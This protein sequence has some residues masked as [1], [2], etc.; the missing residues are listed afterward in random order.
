[1]NWKFEKV[2]AG[3]EK[4]GIRD[5]DI[6]VFDKFRIPSVVR[7]SIQ[8]SLDAV[9]ND[10]EPVR[11]EFLFGEIDKS[12]TTELFVIEDHIKACFNDTKKGTEDFEVLKEM[13][14]KISF[15]KQSIPYLKISDFNTLGMERESAYNAFAF[16]RNINDGKDDASAGSKGMGKS[17]FFSNS[18]LRTILV[19]SIFH[20]PKKK[21]F[22]GISRLASHKLHGEN[23][24]FKGFFGE[25]DFEPV[26]EIPNGILKDIFSRNEPGTTIGIIGTW[27]LPIIGIQDE[28]I[29]TTIKNF[30]LAILNNKLIVKINESLINSNNIYELCIRYW[31]DYSGSKTGENI[32]PRQ[33]LEC[34]LEKV[35]CEKFEKSIDHLG[36]VKLI[37]GKH[38][39]FNGRVSFF[40]KSN[41]LIDTKTRGNPNHGGYAGVFVCEDLE[42]NKIL[43]RLENPRHDEWAAKNWKHPQGGAAL[44]SLQEFISNSYYDFFSIQE[45]ETLT[46]P[47]L[48][49]FL[50]IDSQK[51]KIKGKGFSKN[52]KSGIKINKKESTGGGGDKRIRDLRS[53]TRRN[54]QNEIE[55]HIQFNGVK[56]I[57]NF[58][59]EILVGGD[60]DKASVEN[61]IPLLIFNN[62]TRD[63]RSNE[64]QI[65]IAKGINT[66]TFV[67]D[68]TE[69]HSIWLK[70]L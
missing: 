16:S 28:I 24:Y 27:D 18:Y 5:N 29:K 47:K 45:G 8:N 9:L 30:W 66:I 11:V 21:L 22:Q 58:R 15:N 43:K 70:P 38:H 14:D 42:G 54:S 68:D 59:F 7:E 62:V 35:E 32:N 1:M 4:Q 44:K 34:Y 50:Q 17:A 41:M 36:E 23:Y 64:I 40:R 57:N 26:S 67:L 13:I 65:D 31:P 61:K 10:D 56:K 37:L 25:G 49:E 46:I 51:G 63:N 48:N 69:K 3:I 20:E 2:S 39:D 53:M 12:S 52:I 6:Q 55:Y 60:S 19:S 33:F